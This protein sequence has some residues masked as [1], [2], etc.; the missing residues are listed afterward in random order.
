MDKWNNEIDLMK[1]LTKI[2]C[3][4]IKNNHECEFINYELF[5]AE[6]IHKT[7]Q[8][9]KCYKWRKIIAN[10]QKGIIYPNS[11]SQIQKYFNL[12]IN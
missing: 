7:L 4:N 10:F 11:L 2:W 8:T 6:E 3:D 1:Y 5:I 12:F 9:I